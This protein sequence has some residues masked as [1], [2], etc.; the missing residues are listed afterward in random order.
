MNIIFLFLDV[1]SCGVCGSNTHSC[2]VKTTHVGCVCKFPYTGFDC[3]QSK[4][5]FIL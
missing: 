4:M 2:I 5:I 1:R 3:S